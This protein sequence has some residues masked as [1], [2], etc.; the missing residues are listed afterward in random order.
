VGSKAANLLIPS[1]DPETP[2]LSAFLYNHES[3]PEEAG[4]RL[5]PVLYSL[6]VPEE[7]TAEQTYTLTWSLLGYNEGY[8][9]NIVF[10]DCTGITDGT[11]GNSYGSQ[12]AESGN[13]SPK[14]SEPG[15]WTHNG[16][17]SKKF[18]YTYELTVPTLSQNKEIVVRFYSKDLADA[19]KESLSL[20]IPGNLSSEYYDH[21]GRRLLKHLVTP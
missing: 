15:D 13:L 9:S 6:D 18:H 10:F 5:P 2:L 8:Q 21:E 20:L 14:D 3:G 16:V 12:F 11:C 1:D 17:Q 4:R 19:G 7:M